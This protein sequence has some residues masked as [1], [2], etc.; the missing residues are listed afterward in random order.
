VRRYGWP[1]EVVPGRD[2]HLLHDPGSV[3][4]AVLRLLDQV[5]AGPPAWPRKAD[6]GWAH[7][8]RMSAQE[9]HERLAQSGR[10]LLG[11]VVA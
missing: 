2:L 6:R 3:A 4:D 9:V 11:H 7:D 8:P 5:A 10:V 1:T